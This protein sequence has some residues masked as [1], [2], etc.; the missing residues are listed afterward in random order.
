MK[1]N[2]VK[3][4]LRERL[5]CCASLEDFW[6]EHCNLNNKTADHDNICKRLTTIFNTTDS[7]RE[8]IQIIFLCRQMNCPIPN[9]NNEK[10]KGIVIE[11]GTESGVDALAVYSDLS[12]AWFS[13]KDKRLLEFSISGH[14]Q[15]VYQQ[16][17][18]AADRG[19]QH[20]TSNFADMPMPPPPGYIS[21]IFL[22]ENGIAFGI[23]ASRDIASDRFGGPIIHF[24]LQL[25]K[26]ILEIN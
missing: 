13:G 24:A 21:I 15:T 11:F 7:A 9:E 12:G 23:G 16:L 22:S 1:V 5:L 2:F 17:R 3:S 25:R 14:A 19:S 26:I 4:N 20:A 10:L 8:K 18:D 6:A